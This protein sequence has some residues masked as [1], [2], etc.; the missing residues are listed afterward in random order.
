MKVRVK[1]RKRGLL[2][3]VQLWC[4]GRIGLSW[5]STWLL[6]HKGADEFAQGRDS[7][8]VKHGCTRQLNAQLATEFVPDLNGACIT[9]SNRKLKKVWVSGLIYCTQHQKY[10]ESDHA[11]AYM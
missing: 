2:A 7:R 11:E 9:V 1:V 10:H 3:F 6:C 4:C 5:G 8:I